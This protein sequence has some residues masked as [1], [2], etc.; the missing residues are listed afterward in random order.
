MMDIEQFKAATVGKVIG[1]GYHVGYGYG[2]ECGELASY[3]LSILTNNKYQ[4]A[5][6]KP[7]I[8][9]QWVPGSDCATAWN[10]AYQTDWAAMGFE[11]IDDPSFSQ[12]KPGDIFFISA[13]PGLSTGHVG[14]V[15]SVANN[16][17]STIEQNY[18]GQRYVKLLP[19]KNSWSVYNG[20][21]C[22]VRPKQAN[23]PNTEQPKPEKPQPKKEVNLDMYVIKNLNKKT[24]YICDGFNA[25][26]IKT[27][28]E[29]KFYLG[30]DGHNPLKFPYT[31]MWD[32]E[33]RA[34]YPN[35]K[36]KN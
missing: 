5:Y 32:T 12:L 11:K 27:D 19:G 16:N 35:P 34:I 3:W 36:E 23:K 10:V 25:R 4:M 13:R 29:L 22:I 24:H 21:S 31:E 20:F 18:Y 26:W 9:A 7:D 8:T 2:G 15:Y 14:V 30:Q 33:F 17:V 6:G 1:Y 28:R